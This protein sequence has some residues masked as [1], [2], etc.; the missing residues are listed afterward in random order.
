[1]GLVKVL[2]FIIKMKIFHFGE[3]YRLISFHYFINKQ[4]IDIS[5]LR[6][7]DIGFNKGVFRWY[8]NDVLKCFNYSGVEIDKNYLNIYPNTF[9]HDFEK[10]KLNEYY[11]FIFC[12]HVLEHI[13]NDYK[14]LKNVMH[15]LDSE[16]G[17]LL[18]RVP[19]PTNKKRY[20]R[21]FNSKIH[22]DEEHMRDGYT[23]NDLNGLLSNLGLKS[24]KYFCSMGSLSLATHTLFEIIR[25]YQ[26]R[27]HRG[28]QI[29]YILLSMIDIFLLNN[30]SK[31][32]LLV[33]TVKVPK[34]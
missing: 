15:S 23:V 5:G 19:M 9:Y 1:M 14:F 32:D 18:L 21:A 13:N 20:F 12:S 26:I 30:T 33:L 24:E 22:D 16:N 4:E 11:D 34:E 31:S 10:Y 8:F 2:I 28:L 27:F 3:I 7:L 25:D 17:K 6:V 29:P